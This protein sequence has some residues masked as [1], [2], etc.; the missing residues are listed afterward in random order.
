MTIDFNIVEWCAVA[1]IAW[2]VGF[3]TWVA[4]YKGEQK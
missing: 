2:A 3:I 1:L 4:T